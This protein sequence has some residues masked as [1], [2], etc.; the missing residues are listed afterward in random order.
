MLLSETTRSYQKNFAAFCRTGQYKS[1]PGVKESNMYKYRELIYNVVDDS[2]ASA[3]P[4]TK[5]LLQT[6]EWDSLV[7]GFL[8]GHFCKSAQIWQMPRELMD[9]VKEN[10][11]GL[12]K[13][14][15]FLMDLLLFEWME[16]EVFMMKDI[17][18]DYTLL[19]DFYKDKLVVNPE[20]RIVPLLYPVHLKKAEEIFPKDKRQYFVS[21]HRVTD[22]SKVRFTDLQYPHVE[23][24]QKLA[25]A[26]VN[27]IRL[28]EVFTK[29]GDAETATNALIHFLKAALRSKLILGY[30]K[31]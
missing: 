19:G 9:F 13:K 21:V 8:A 31:H 12:L 23:V 11:Y 25:E 14:Y 7:H 16:V 10:D 30:E 5:N 28:M 24:L 20:L 18:F 2:L 26:P 1:I 4:L 27:F 22:K 15:P 29:Y 17:Q 3:Y 6:K